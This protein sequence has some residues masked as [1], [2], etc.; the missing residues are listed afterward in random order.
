MS[1]FQRFEDIKVWQE[2][3]KLNKEIYAISGAGEFARDYS[4]KNQ[5]RDAS[6]SVMGNIAEG[7]ERE[8]NAEFRQF[9]SNAKGSAGEVRSHLYSAL[10]A[11]HINQAQFDPL[12]TQTIRITAMLAALIQ[13]LNKCDIRGL[14]FKTPPKPQRPDPKAQNRNQNARNKP[15]ETNEP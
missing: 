11:G 1:T 10:D 5:I 14:K 8:G 13:Y 12:A 9:C 2:A 6:V 4:L 3:R 7:F 15:T